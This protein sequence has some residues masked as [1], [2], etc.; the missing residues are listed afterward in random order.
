MKPTVWL[1]GGLGP[2]HGSFK[3]GYRL[4][5][6][7]EGSKRLGNRIARHFDGGL[8]GRVGESTAERFLKRIKR[9]FKVARLKLLPTQVIEQ[10]AKPRPRL[11]V[12]FGELNASFRPRHK[13]FM[14]RRD[15]G[16]HVSCVNSDEILGALKGH[17]ERRFEQRECRSRLPARSEQTATLQ[18]NPRARYPTRSQDLGFKNERCSGLEVITQACSAGKLSE[19]FCPTVSGHLLGELITQKLIG[20]IKVREIP[21]GS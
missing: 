17:G 14:V 15:Q 21:E 6:S 11:S 13:P 18:I 2:S 9:G 12:L 3:Q 19:N 7:T 5:G 4:I 20:E 10:G 1:T 16:R 8:I